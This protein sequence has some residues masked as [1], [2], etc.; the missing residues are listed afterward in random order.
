M[1]LD[2]SSHMLAACG[3]PS[4]PFV[5]WHDGGDDIPPYNR[6]HPAIR[7][8]D[9]HEV[10]VWL[11]GVTFLVPFPCMHAC[12]MLPYHRMHPAPAWCNLSLGRWGDMF[13]VHGRGPHILHTGALHVACMNATARERLRLFAGSNV[14]RMALGT[15]MK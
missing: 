6:M 7:P 11:V 13:V 14:P 4:F 3:A 9:R 8:R 15:S 2:D 5:V 1:S 12:G 10:S